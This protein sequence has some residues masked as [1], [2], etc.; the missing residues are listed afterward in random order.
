MFLEKQLKHVH[1]YSFGLK[2][3]LVSQL[4]RYLDYRDESLVREFFTEN[5]QT[6]RDKYKLKCLDASA[7]R[8][9][10]SVNVLRKL[11]DSIPIEFESVSHLIVVFELNRCSSSA[12]KIEIEI[13]RVIPFV[14]AYYLDSGLIVYNLTRDINQ[15]LVRLL[16]LNRSRIKLEMNLSEWK[17]APVNH[18]TI[19]RKQEYL[20]YSD[21]EQVVWVFRLASDEKKL[22]AR[23]PMYGKVRSVKF[24]H[25]S[26]FLCANMNDCRLYSMQLVDPLRVEHLDEMK[27]METRRHAIKLARQGKIN[28]RKTKELE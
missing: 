15:N 12:R 5:G 25:D 10:L 13:T 23:L 4:V 19:D 27:K 11:P 17:S 24:D 8:Y 2:T 7:E 26:R 1:Y 22:I 21:A 28:F 18:F 14:R 3:W 20:A 6:E 9:L 16:D